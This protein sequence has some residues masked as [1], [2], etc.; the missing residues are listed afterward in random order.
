MRASKRQREVI[1]IIIMAIML[2]GLVVIANN[3]LWNSPDV[4]PLYTTILSIIGMLI[5]MVL[6]VSWLQNKEY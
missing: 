5:L 3:R 6:Y 1:T 2:V 4:V